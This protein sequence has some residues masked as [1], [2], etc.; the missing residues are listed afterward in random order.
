MPR[1]PR[2][3]VAGAVYHV[4]ARGNRRQSIYEDERD[5]ARFAELLTVVVRRRR[6]RCH[7]YCLMPNHYHL[8]LETPGD[9]SAGLQ[10][11]NGQYAQWFNHRHAVTGH[12]FQGRFHAVLVQ[13]DW[14][15]LQLSRYIV[16]NPVRAGLAA[17]PEGW[18]WSSFRSVVGDAPRPRFLTTEWLLGFFG[19]DPRSARDTY[20]RFA[21][22]GPT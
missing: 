1:P 5:R 9:L 21:R 16:L 10:E 13:S 15:A 7:A 11:L 4:T 14:H 19:K 12:L 2:V 3:I 22:D 20:R 8:V 17:G 18:K 6:W